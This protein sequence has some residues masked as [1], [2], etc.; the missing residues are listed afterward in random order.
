MHDYCITPGLC[1]TT[2]NL[3]YKKEKKYINM[4]GRSKIHNYAVYLQ[5]AYLPPLPSNVTHFDYHFLNN[6]KS[7]I[8]FK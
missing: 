5:L 4:E 1:V 3:V 2:I 7:L 8:K 6:R